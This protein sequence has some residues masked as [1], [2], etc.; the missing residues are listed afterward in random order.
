MAICRAFSYKVKT[1]TTDADF[2][3]IPYAFPTEPPLPKIDALKSHVAFLAGIKPEIYHCCPNSCCCYVGPHANLQK[4]PYC[5]EPRFRANGRARKCFTYIPLIPR[6]QAFAANK[7]M[8]EQ[9]QYRSHGHTHVMG[10][11]SDVFDGSHYRTLC[12][13][14]VTL[15]HEKY[16]H[17]YFADKRDIALGLSTD[18]FAPFKQRKHTA[19]P[20]IVFNYNLPPETRFHLSNILTLGVIP[21][22]KNPVDSDSFIWP[23][24][25]E[26]F[27]LAKGVPAFDIMSSR[28][29]SLHAWLILVFGDIPAISI[30]MQMKGHNGLSPCRM[31]EILGLRI[32]G[33]RATTHYVPLDRTR[34][35]HICANASAI[36]TYDAA[37]L[38]LRDHHMFMVQGREVQSADST[39]SADKLAKKY[40]IKGVPLLSHLPSLSFPTSFP[41]DFMHLIWENLIK[42]LVLL[43]TGEF[44]GLDDG[45]ES[46]EV[47]KAIWEAIGESTAA[48]GSTIPS[49]YGSRVPNISTSSSQCSAEMWSFWTLYLGPVLLRRRFENKYYQHF[50]RL[51]RLL[52]I[53]LQFEI[54]DT[55]I[56]KI[57]TG[58]IHWVQEYEK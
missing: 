6:L 49:T 44:K 45:R 30:I 48:S 31:C 39:S 55:E 21:G 32:P 54:T 23:F 40:G 57:R 19:W 7:S 22:P 10:T 27:R 43:W 3:K 46:Y 58:F 5:E 38:P 34:H 33:A 9:M 50:I 16:Q 47:S 36:Q 26:M 52:T 15:G 41:Y 1:H 24:V 51:V 18:G 35:P 13:Q 2:N 12:R 4:C 14:Q 53:C 29:F 17:N 11:M 8:A 28:L 56:E 37:C 25:Q 20:L 42:N